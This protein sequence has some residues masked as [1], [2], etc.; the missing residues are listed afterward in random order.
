MSQANPLLVPELREMLDTNDVENIKLFCEAEHPAIIADFLSALEPVEIFEILKHTNL[1]LQAKIISHLTEDTQVAV[2]E[3]MGKLEIAKLLGEMAHDDRADI[4]KQLSKKLQNLILPA[5]AQ[6]EREDIR[7]LAS[8][9]EGTAGAVMTSDYATLALHLTTSEAVEV[10]RQVAPDKETI[11]YT[12]ILDDNR[13][14]LGM[15]S[16]KDIIVATKDT[17]LS[18]IIETDIAYAMVSDHQ[19][20]VAHKMRK[21]DIIALPVLN[22]DESMVGI[23]TFDD[24]EDVIVEEATIDFHSLGAI[25]Q[26]TDGELSGID[27]RDTSILLMVRKRLPWLL[28]LV[29]VNII[30]GAGIAHFESTIQ[31]VVAL[32]FFLPLLIDSGGN[33]GS[34][35][36]TLMVRALATGQAKMSDWL[37]LLTKEVLVASILGLGM[38]LAAS[39]L[40]FWRG[41]P[42]IA[43][44]VSLTM[45]CIV[46]FGSL[47]GMS[48]PFLL[49]KLKLDPATAS[50]PLITSLA[51]I[52]GIL[53]YFNIATYFLKDKIG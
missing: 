29:F 30:S 53:I 47:V 15:V 23:I 9:E 35:S 8:Y 32:V 33:A 12:Y 7:R 43:L 49:N 3:I 13:K 42:E 2:V 26:P 1:Q 18:E 38:G 31:A 44:I 34:Q 6:A 17:P 5:L 46:V 41:G 48:L 11:Y 10:L 45:A 28:I 40:G 14:L 25:S 22:E 51:D 39:V 52:G 16:L 19:E 20:D 21:Y 37:Y 4:F 27:M 36:S 50:A 24:I